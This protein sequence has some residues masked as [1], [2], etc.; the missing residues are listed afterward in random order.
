MARALGSVVADII[1]DDRDSRDDLE[2]CQ[3]LSRMTP[4]DLVGAYLEY[5]YL[6]VVHIIQ[7]HVPGYGPH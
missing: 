2:L 5:H 3:Q 6:E 1:E 7:Q 4:A